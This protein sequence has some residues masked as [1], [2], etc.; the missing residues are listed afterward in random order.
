MAEAAVSDEHLADALGEVTIFTAGGEQVKVKDLWD[1]QEG[2]AVVALLRHFGC[3][4][5]WE[6]ALALKEVKEKLDSW[7][8][9]VVAVGVGTPDKAKLLAHG[10]PFPM[11]SLYADPDRKAY[12]VLGLHYGLLRTLANPVELSARLGALK[13]STSNYTLK[14][15]PNMSSILQ[16]GGMF[17]FKGKKV[18]Y[19][20][21]DER[22]GDHAPLDD[23]INVCSKVAAA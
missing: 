19:A 14:A 1:Q 7:G 22:T 18:V 11:D 10:L 9:K 20:R 15:T 8:V 21:K 17:V 2:V 23:V 13:K 4:C 3:F 12:E 6:L 16:Q 5:S